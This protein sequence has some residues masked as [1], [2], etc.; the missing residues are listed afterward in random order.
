[1]KRSEIRAAKLQREADAWNTKHPVGTLVRYWTG[2]HEGKPSGIGP[3]RWAA[4]PMGDHVSVWVEGCVGSVCVSHV[5]AVDPDLAADLLDA[6]AALAAERAAERD[7][8]LELVADDAVAVA[9]QRTLRPPAMTPTLPIPP[10]DRVAA[11]RRLVGDALRGLTRARD[12]WAH[13]GQPERVEFLR[14]ASNEASRLI[15]AL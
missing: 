11:M 5:E 13:M 14:S 8:A 3:V 1:M 2:L 12:L 6:H 15:R 9:R 10:P 7:A 4:Q